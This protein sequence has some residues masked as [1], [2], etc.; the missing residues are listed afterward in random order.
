MIHADRPI[1]APQPVDSA[2]NRVNPKTGL[3]ERG[4]A[5]AHYAGIPRP[6]KAF[7]FSRY[8]ETPVCQALDQLFHGKC[9]YC[10]SP[11][12]AVDALDVEHFRP[13][14]GVDEAPAHPGYWWLAADWRNLLPSCPACNQRRK[15][16]EYMPGMSLEAIERALLAKPAST[17]GKANRFPMLDKNW[18]I[19]VDADLAVEDPLLINPCDREP[20]IYLEWVF[21]RDPATPIWNADPV[22]PFLRARLAGAG[23]DP[24]GDASIKIFGLNR[25]GVVKARI[26]QVRSI[27]RLCLPIINTL[28]ILKT[29]A[30][31]TTP[32][33]QL[34]FTQLA[35]Y[36]ATLQQTTA[37]DELY[38]GMARAFFREFEDDLARFP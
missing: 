12:R 29:Q 24:H 13:K 15:H 9:A 33:A 31:T 14:G 34:L 23:D 3:T 18:V 30:D 5:N 16:V 20:E 19:A 6:S 1:P 4:E 17:S 28:A 37:P 26:Q 11:Y 2:L 25:V 38:A 32:L 35:Q 7:D 22:V 8:R 10:E 21:D 27:Q 36:K